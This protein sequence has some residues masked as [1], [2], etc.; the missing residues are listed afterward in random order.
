[1]SGADRGIPNDTL[2][3]SSMLFL[4]DLKPHEGDTRIKNKLSDGDIKIIIHKI[5][6]RLKQIDQLVSHLFIHVKEKVEFA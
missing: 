6:N 3:S 1:M 4:Y 5:A 2:A